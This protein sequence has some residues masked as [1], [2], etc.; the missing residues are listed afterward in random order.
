MGLRPGTAGNL[1][2]RIPPLPD[3]GIVTVEAA[4]IERLACQI[5]DAGKQMVESLA[6]CSVPYPAAPEE[7]ER[8]NVFDHLTG[9]S[10]QAE[11][12]KSRLRVVRVVKAPVTYF[13]RDSPD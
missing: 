13:R 3:P 11:I 12:C 6:V 4:F 9:R 2:K 1:L 5:L 10:F 8:S 7:G